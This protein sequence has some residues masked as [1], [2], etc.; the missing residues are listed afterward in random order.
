MTD[1]CLIPYCRHPTIFHVVSNRLE[2][3][4]V[5][6]VFEKFSW[7][8]GKGEKVLMKTLKISGKSNRRI[9]AKR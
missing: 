1:F 9:I 3:M 6:S 2:I 7:I 8:L 4:L 5:L